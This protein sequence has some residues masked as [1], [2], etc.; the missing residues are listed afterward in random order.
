[1]SD[2]LFLID[3][4]VL[5]LDRYLKAFELKFKKVGDQD[6]PP[7]GSD[8]PTVSKFAKNN[9]YVIITSDDNMKKQCE[10]LDVPFVFNDLTDFAKKVKAY[11]ESH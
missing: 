1:M 4:N 9:G 7:T 5:G 10:T 6:C 8:D 3:E 2:I 11:A